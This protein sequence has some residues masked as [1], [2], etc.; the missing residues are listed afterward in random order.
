MK[1]IFIFPLVFICFSAFA[2]K[3]EL[4][5]IDSIVNTLPALNDDSNKVKSLAKI[6]ET[7]LNLDPAKG[8]DYAKDGLVIAEKLKWIRGTAR[9]NNLLGLLVGDTGNNTRARVYFE[10]S[11]ALNKTLGPSFSMISNLNNIGRSYQR[12][13]QYSMAL[14]Y[15]L[16]ALS[17]AE[18]LKSDQQIALVC[19]NLTA[20]YVT[21]ND[22]AK[23]L[24]YGEMTL[25]YAKLSNTPDNIGKALMNLS[26]IKADLKDTAAAKDYIGQSLQVYEAM[27]KKTAVA[28]ALAVKATLFYPDYKEAIDQML[29]A[30]QL[31]DEIGPSSLSSI[32]NL[33][34]LGRAYYELSRQSQAP[35]KNEL[36]NKAIS[37]L[38]RGILLSKQTANAEYLAN[39]YK[40]LSNVEE[41][42]GEYRPALNNFRSYYAIND[43]LFSQDKKNELAALENKHKIDLKDQEIAIS[44]LMLTNQQRTLLGLVIGLILLGFIGTLLVWQNRMRKKTNTALLALN[45]RLDEANKIKTRFFGI[46]SHD[47]RSPISNL[48]NYLYLLRNEPGQLSTEEQVDSQQQISQSTE[49]LLQ[50]LETMLLWS[51]DQMDHFKPDI[52]MITVNALFDYL[53]KFFAPGGQENIRFSNPENLQILTDENYLKVIMQNLTSNAI[54]A[55]PHTADASIAWKARKEGKQILLSISDN[56]PGINEQQVKAI[57]N[58]TDGFNAKTGFGFHLIRDLAKAIHFKI[59]VDSKP[60]MGTTFILST[61]VYEYSV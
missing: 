33:S 38:N 40:T 47:L 10:K 41:E 6:A 31:L 46:L 57:Y 7:Y 27:G 21:Q 30:Q 9:L 29:K 53:Q 23:A 3:T 34:N 43:S 42:R 49:E 48:M 37:N 45:N 20:S 26:V 8:I 1:F 17:I 39:M 32:G 14:D 35:E 12:E 54:K 51:K 11:Y 25:K 44:K 16:K 13:S 18:E 60:G 56:G 19:T 2:Q 24:A 55:V 28:M 52:R 58:E 15:F 50:T 4:V 36:L 59:A 22:Y 61:I 5:L